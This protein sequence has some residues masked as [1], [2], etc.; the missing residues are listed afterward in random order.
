MR[1]WLR[2]RLLGTPYELGGRVP[3]VGIDC[4]GVVLWILKERGQQIPDPWETLRAQY[5]D[6]GE[7]CA[8]NGLP[9]GWRRLEEGEPLRD[10]DVLLGFHAHHWSA[11]VHEGHVWTAKPG[12]GVWSRPVNRWSMRPREVWRQC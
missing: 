2:R 3:G 6:P 9:A 7:S 4:L 1:A 10:G 11:V 5:A 8:Q 12:T